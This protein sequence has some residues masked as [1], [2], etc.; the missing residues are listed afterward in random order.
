MSPQFADDVS[1]LLSATAHPVMEDFL[2]ANKLFRDM[3][4]SA[5]Q[6]A[7]LHGLFICTLSMRLR[8]SNGFL[9]HGPIPAIV[10][11]RTALGQEVL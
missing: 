1:M 7:V 11:D 9:V 8:G 6:F 4:R 2:D 5:V 10:F 3:R